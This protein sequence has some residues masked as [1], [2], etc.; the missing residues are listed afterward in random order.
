MFLCFGRNLANEPVLTNLSVWLH[1]AILDI[2]RP[3]IHLAPNQ[4]RLK[5]FSCDINTPD[6]VYMSSV[7]QLKRLILVYRSKYDS[8]AYTILW[9]TALLY[10][11]N[12][13]LRDKESNGRR[14][15][16]L[17]CLYGYE[18]LQP[19]YR[20]VKAIAKGLL[21]MALHNGAIT[22]DAARR[23]LADLQNK[24]QEPVSGVI[25]ANFMLDLD[26]ALLEPEAATAET[27]AETF[28]ENAM[29]IDYTN[30]LDGE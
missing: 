20:V 17:L 2:F 25:R 19:S 13:V 6:A 4:L 24:A 15:Y 21:S 29:M 12:A 22:G 3:F 10:V 14:F 11:A 16:L 27:L 30:V 8:S 23:I 26:L 7:E 28:E 9:H 5:T 18:R 1:A